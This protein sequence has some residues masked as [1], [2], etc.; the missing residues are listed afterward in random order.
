[1]LK[2]R[3]LMTDLTLV[4]FASL[5]V[6]FATVAFFWYSFSAHREKVQLHVRANELLQHSQAMLAIPLW[7]LEDH[8]IQIALLQYKEIPMVK[9]ISVLDDH[10]NLLGEVNNADKSEDFSIE[11][12]IVYKKQ[13]VGFIRMVFSE[14]NLKAHEAQ[15]L[16]YAVL[17]FFLSLTLM[18]FSM[19][20]LLRRYFS[21][22][23]QHIKQGILTIAH[24]QYGHLIAP[25]PQEDL[26]VVI[27]A[28]N[29]LSLEVH[30]RN[31]DLQDNYARMKLAKTVQEALLPPVSF[32]VKN[33]VIYW[34]YLPMEDVGGDWFHFIEDES[35]GDIYAIIGDVTGHGVAAS[36]VTSALAG[37][38]N[39]MGTQGLSPTKIMKQMSEIVLRVSDSSQLRMSCLVA[40][41]NFKKAQ[42]CI[43][44]AGHPF[45]LLLRKATEPEF[46]ELESLTK[47][48]NNLLGDKDSGAFFQETFY[49]INK[50]DVLLLFTDGLTQALGMD[51]QPFYKIMN[52]MLKKTKLALDTHD[53]KEQMIA[54]YRQ[55]TEGAQAEDDVCLIVISGTEHK[56]HGNQS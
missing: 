8:D 7:N 48:S 38:F 2:R 20:F 31:Q 13:T 18:L 5:F 43:C 34:E 19:A 40:K 35:Q 3:T 39:K 30:L 55:H 41:V 49:E 9:K 36:L 25:L 6:S 44:N 10:K 26:N 54:S 14:E 4:I 12:P 47:S 15:L 22:P 42:L 46:Y 23:L 11:A 52:K 53:I 33:A 50:E 56:N 27:R 51:Q 24:G 1:M 17:T 28:V 21:Q 16:I 29:N 37:A 45:P 32:T